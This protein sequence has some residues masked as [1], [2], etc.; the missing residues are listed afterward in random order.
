MKEK[1]TNLYKKI[2]VFV[3]K[4]KLLS[5]IILITLTIFVY[6]IF[7]SS[8]PKTQIIYSVDKVS[9]ETIVSYVS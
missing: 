5:V 3:F 4:R 9:R 2:Y 8:T 7:F 1:L 6:K